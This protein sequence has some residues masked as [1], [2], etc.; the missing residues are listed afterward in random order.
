ML[1]SLDN[2]HLYHQWITVVIHQL[3]YH[4]LAKCLFELIISSFYPTSW[5]LAY[6]LGDPYHSLSIIPT[7]NFSYKHPISSWF[8]HASIPIY[9]PSSHRFRWSVVLPSS[10]GC[11][12]WPRGTTRGTPSRNVGEVGSKK[13]HH[14]DQGFIRVRSIGPRFHENLAGKLGLSLVTTGWGEVCVANQSSSICGSCK[15]F[16]PKTSRPP[17]LLQPQSQIIPNHLTGQHWWG[18]GRAACLD[19]IIQVPFYMVMIIGLESLGMWLLSSFSVG[20]RL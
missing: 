18:W 17:N 16:W 15:L 13:N 7:S 5:L 20:D 11:R 14:V 8:H 10:R 12:S 1:T 19:L 3:T 2:K 6:H 4:S 9:P